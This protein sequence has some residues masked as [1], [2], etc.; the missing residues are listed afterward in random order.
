[1]NFG[2]DCVMFSTDLRCIRLSLTSSK[3]SF[4]PVRNLSAPRL[5]VV[6]LLASV[7]LGVPGAGAQLPGLFLPQPTNPGSDPTQSIQRPAPLLRPSAPATIPRSGQLIQPRGGE[8]LLDPRQAPA[9]RV[10]DAVPDDVKKVAKPFGWELFR[11]TAAIARARGVNPAYIISPGD[12]IALQIWGAKVAEY[13]LT[14]DQ[15]G[16]LFIPE[17]GPVRVAGL[18]QDA[19]N[20]RIVTAMLT[21]FTKKVRVY[22]N[23]LNTQPIG[24][25]VTGAV[26]KPGRYAGERTDSL[27]YYIGQSGGIDLKRGSFRDIR[28]LRGGGEIERVDLYRFLLR[29]EL[30]TPQLRSN[31]TIIIGPLRSTITAGGSVRNAYIF[32]VGTKGSTGQTVIGMAKPTPDVSHVQVRGVRAGRPYNAYITIN[33][34]RGAPL[35]DGDTLVFRSDMVGETI[36]VSISGQSSG[37]SSF[38]VPRGTRLNKVLDIIAVDPDTAHLAAIYLRRKSIAAIQKAAL[39]R[40]LDQLQREVLTAASTSGTEAGIR[41]AEAERITRYIDKARS[42]VPEG[43]VVL[44]GR[45]AQIRLESDDEIVIPQKSAL[46]TISGEVRLPQAIAFR[47]GEDIEFYIDQAGG[48]SSRAETDEFIIIHQSGAVESGSRLSIQPG[49]QV[50][51]LPSA[52]SKAFAIVKDIIEVMSRVILSSGVIINILND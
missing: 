5:F 9:V 45:A 15:Q 20:Q 7:V 17:V 28:V 32:E 23:L 37:P 51:V 52:G 50:I 24:V 12:K 16:N 44:D 46:I 31:D 41:A 48:F 40:S 8:V 38:A 19:L 3:K 2:V 30:P 6:A 21:I 14:V 1:M 33:E 35:N 25:Y 18:K 26:V 47:R 39:A 29:G 10:T 11:G 49:D 22:T 13:I 4:A 43:R 36:F 27:L 42:V 34:F